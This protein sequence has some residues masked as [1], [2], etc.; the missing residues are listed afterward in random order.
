MSP[1]HVRVTMYIPNRAGTS[2]NREHMPSESLWRINMDAHGEPGEV[3]S[4][5]VPFLFSLSV[6]L[7]LASLLIWP[8]AILAVPMLAWSIFAWVREDV[9]LWELRTVSPEK[10]GHASWAMVWIIL[11]EVIVFAGFFAFWF[12]AKWHTVSWDGAIASSSWPPAEIHH[13]MMLVMF[14]TALLLSSGIIAHLSLHAHDRGSLARSRRHLHITI[15]F[16]A[17]FLA[18]QMY[19]YMHTGFTWKDHPYG[20]AFFA[21]TGLHGLHVLVGIIA[22]GGVAFL[23]KRG[24]Y[25]NGRRDSF[26]AVIWY[27]HFVDVVWIMLFLIV[28]VEVI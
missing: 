28:Y 1:L 19:E 12:W 27:W 10:M 18:I 8:I 16:G 22:L 23:H 20:T 13:N 11:T 2:M 6:T 4:S 3:H 9:T 21:L 14:N 5:L 26:Q 25:D 7:A 24:H 17:L 15:G